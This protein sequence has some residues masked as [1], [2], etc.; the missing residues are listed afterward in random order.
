MTYTLDAA[1]TLRI[2]YQRTTDK[3]TLVNLT[4]HTYF[5]L[6]GEGTGPIVG[7]VLALNADRYTPVDAT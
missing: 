1:T 3:P 4:N 7:H 2:D 5:N 6:A